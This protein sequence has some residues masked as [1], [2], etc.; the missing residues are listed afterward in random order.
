MAGARQPT[1]SPPPPE[2]NEL[3]NYTLGERIG[4]DEL[5][6][7]YRARH[8]TLDRDVHVYIL[9]RAGWVAVS[10]FQLAAR[11]AAKYVNPHILPVLDGGH[12]EKWGYYMVTPPLVA[13]PLQALLEKGRID[14]PQ[15]LRIFAHIGQA[16]DF[17]HSQGVVHRDVQPQTIL[18]GEDGRAILTGF[19]LAWTADG[20][21]L[22][23]LAEADYLTPYAAP[24]Q[25]FEDRTPAPAL[26]LYALGAVLYHML[27][28]EVPPTPGSEPKKL[29]EVDPRL[30]PAD[31]V[32][33]RMLS[34]QPGMRYPSA[35]Q[36]AAALR[37]TLRPSLGEGSGV[38][39][40]E[41][42]VEANWLE[43]PLEIVLRERIDGDFMRRSRERAEALH[44]G[45]GVRRL[46]DEWSADRP[47]RRR[48]LG[49]TVRI[50]QVV[51]YN[52]YFYDLKTLYE[53]RTAPQNRERPYSGSKVNH[54][55]RDLDRWKVV[56]ETPNASFADVAPSE[57]AIPNSEK[58]SVCP[59]CHGETRVTCG[60]CQGRGTV[61]VKRTV[62]TSTGTHTEVEVVDCPECKG[63]ALLTCDRCD[64][65]GGL[66]EQKLFTFSRRGRLWQNSDDLEGLPQRA[67]E[68]R[69]EQVFVGMIDVHDP[70]WHAAQPLH[71]LFSEATKLERDDTRIVEAELIIRATPVTE[72]DYT[73]RGK[74][75]TLAIMGFDSGIRG[76][77]SLL[78]TERLL[79]IAAVV[80][81]VILLAVI[82]W[83]KRGG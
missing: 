3:K 46:L 64:G 12:D 62:S 67:I 59:R 50:D 48:Q 74:P 2:A 38:Q 33:R 76:D 34:P 81:I 21:D 40:T 51:S 55:E 43:N 47:Q 36:A 60:R 44:T 26:D 54:R 23:Q 16:L 82:F 77:L 9:R 31:R 29:G 24:E 79:M 1:K 35:A 5:S 18:V 10:R 27:T 80:V 58:S 4:Q 53:T 42:A 83:F 32:L 72:V 13:K 70:V 11:L 57:V 73:L 49:Q 7:V 17:L 14:P 15:A 25:T 8:Q 6:T 37:G 20:P 22:S 71:E 63:A 66:M 39:V 28:G 65:T 75:R 41:G 69:S 68:S 56:V 52:L 45:E 78:D 61:D 19:S 30:Q